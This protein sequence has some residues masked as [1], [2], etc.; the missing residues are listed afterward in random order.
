MF[1]NKKLIIVIP[2]YNAENTLAK[3]VSE[4]PK[5]VVDR[6]I[7]TDDGSMDNTG[8]IARKLEILTFTHDQNRGYGAAMKTCFT[9]ALE[10]NPNIIVVLH[11]DNQYEPKL[12]NQMAS[13]IDE[14]VYDVVLASRMLDKDVFKIMPFYRYV[15]NKILT[16]IQNLIFGYKLTEYHTGYRAYNANVLRNVSY[17]K[18]SND[19]VF[20]NELLTQIFFNKFKVTEILCP[21]VYN[22]ETSSISITKSFKYFFGVLTTSLKY[23]LHKLKLKKYYILS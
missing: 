10:L 5:G 11:S 7:L 13:I 2:A 1:K 21:T 16:F 15:A 8:I 22:L 9:K 23:L 17:L 14:G 3:T 19:F 20:D 18:N 6:I 4:I 12:I